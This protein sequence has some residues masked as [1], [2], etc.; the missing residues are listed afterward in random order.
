MT[1]DYYC[2]CLSSEQY[3]KQFPV[4]LSQAMHTL[5]Q[6]RDD[7]KGILPTSKTGDQDKTVSILSKAE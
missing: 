3:V 7:N 1:I 5:L 6:Q 4:L 2:L